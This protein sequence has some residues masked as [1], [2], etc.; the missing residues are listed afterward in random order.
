VVATD[1]GQ[2]QGHQS[3]GGLARQQGPGEDIAQID[4]DV[5]AAPGYIV[6]HRVERTQISVNVRDCRDSHR[7]TLA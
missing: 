3:F 4:G 5:Y 7:V 6:Q 1:G 2:V